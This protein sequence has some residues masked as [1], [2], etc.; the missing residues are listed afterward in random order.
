LD[1]L[2]SFWFFFWGWKAQ[3]L[4]GG[5]MGWQTSSGL[6]GKT[7]PYVNYQ[8]FGGYIGIFLIALWMSRKHL[9]GVSRKFFG[10]G[11]VDDSDEPMTYR[12]AILALLLG[13]TFLTLFCYNRS[14]TLMEMV[15]DR[16]KKLAIQLK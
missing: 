15:L 12:G 16:P 10:K 1:L 6:G 5:V 2:F 9:L 3:L 14:L 7:Y 13:A 11:E 4:L 8:G